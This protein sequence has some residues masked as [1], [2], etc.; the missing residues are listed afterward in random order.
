MLRTFLRQAYFQTLKFLSLETVYCLGDS[1]IR[2]FNHPLFKLAFPH[3]YFE[4]VAV[5][6]TTA[7]GLQN[8][9]SKTQARTIFYSVLEKLDKPGKVIFN[10]GEVDCAM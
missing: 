8:P 1:H 6:G 9:H 7:S 10:L 3:L 2:V 4:I 5:D